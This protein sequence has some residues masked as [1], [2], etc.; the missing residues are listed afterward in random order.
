MPFSRPTNLDVGSEP[1]LASVQYRAEVPYSGLWY[2]NLGYYQGPAA[3]FPSN[4]QPMALYDATS[5]KTF[6]VWANGYSPAWATIGAYNHATGEIVDVNRV[7]DLTDTDGHRNP[8]IHIDSAGYIYVFAAA[9][10]SPIWIKKSNAPRDI[11]A[12]SWSPSIPGNCTYSQP[13]A[14][15]AGE[16]TVF[17]RTGPDYG[18]SY[19]R[20]T[21]GGASWGPEVRVV[22]PANPV[23]DGVYAQTASRSGTVHIVWTVLDSTTQLRK[24]FWY[25][26]SAGGVA[27]TRA[28]G[29]AL[30]LPIDARTGGELVFNS[31]AD[32]VNTQDIQIDSAGNPIILVSHGQNPGA[33]HWKLVKRVAGTWQAYS[34]GAVGDRQFD[35][36]GLILD[37]DTLFRALLPTGAGIAGQDGGNIEEW[38]STDAGLT[39]ALNRTLT[40]D[41]LN[42][43]H[44]KVA[45]N[46]QPG[47][48]AFWSYGNPSIASPTIVKF[49]DEVR[50]VDA[51]RPGNPFKR[52]VLPTLNGVALPEQTLTAAE[53]VTVVLSNSGIVGTP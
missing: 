46:G 34:V 22:S 33:W 7:M 12:W 15:A 26:K 29:T 4:M 5:N 17:H 51:L 14:L 25:A 6:F 53:P 2:G 42:H 27:W 28:D 32:Q 50:G 20:S 1:L 31:G 37:S 35:N 3:T 19:R 24:N 48:R 8:T 38:L 43:N 30:T 21:N 45:Q 52:Y 36:G 10:N 49:L 44:V 18:W 41:P 47:F 39:W 11:T 40:A 9:K 16:I 23:V 13:H